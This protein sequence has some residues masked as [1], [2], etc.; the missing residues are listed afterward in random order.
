MVVLRSC[1]LENCISQIHTTLL[2]GLIFTKSKDVVD[3]AREVALCKGGFTL[4]G[5]LHFALEF[6]P[7]LKDSTEFRFTFNHVG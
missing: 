7:E 4:Q 1:E 3:F 6:A 2:G 5:R